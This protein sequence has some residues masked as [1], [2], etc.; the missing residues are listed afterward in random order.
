MKRQKI[1][2]IKLASHDSASMRIVI[3]EKGSHSL[4]RCNSKWIDSRSVEKGVDTISASN[5]LVCVIVM[6]DN[7]GWI[8]VE[9]GKMRVSWEWPW[10]CCFPCSFNCFDHLLFLQCIASNSNLLH[11]HLYF[12]LFC[13]WYVHMRKIRSDRE[14]PFSIHQVFWISYRLSLAKITISNMYLFI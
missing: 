14:L 1:I 11:F 2:I 13:S 10:L 6:V 3:A 9:R 8:L 12:Y 4:I 5:I 7:V